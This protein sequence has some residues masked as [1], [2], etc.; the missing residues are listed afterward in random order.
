[1]KTTFIVNPASANGATGRR[2]AEVSRRLTQLGV[3]HETATT[4]A[5]G[6]ATELAHQALVDGVDSVIAVGGDGTLNEVANGFFAEGRYPAAALGLLPLG[7]G[8]DFRRTFNLPLALEEAAL[9]FKRR[10]LRLIDVGRIEMNGLDGSP[11][12]RHFVN[13]ADAGIGGVVVERVNNTSKRLGG[14]VS[15][16]YASIRVLLSY[17]PQEV[18][19]TSAEGSFSGRAQ[20]VVVANCRYFGGGMW[21]APEAVPDDGLFDVVVFGD[22]ARYEAIRSIQS[23]YKGAHVSNPKVKGW[24][25]ARVEVT[26]ED[27]VLIDV[28][29][30]MC[31][32]L[33]ASFEL[34]P[35]ALPLIVP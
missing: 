5:P 3:E 30:E 20:N 4:N 18:T 2:W 15:F 8:G 6:H 16:Q 34:L 10:K 24:R 33:P 7:T 17:V 31:G 25:S 9:T 1:M 21:V 12:T 27:R 26:S 35:K 11:Y 28:D 23:I 14:R 22:I 13:I 29:G 32:T 19:V